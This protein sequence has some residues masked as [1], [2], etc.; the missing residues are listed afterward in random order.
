MPLLFFA[1]AAYF[2]IR[3]CHTDIFISAFDI[4]ARHYALLLFIS[5]ALR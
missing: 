5:F 2:S 4:F 1:I 3:R